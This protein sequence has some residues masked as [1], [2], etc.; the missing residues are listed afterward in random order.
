[1]DARAKALFSGLRSTCPTHS[2]QEL[3]NA[4]DIVNNGSSIEVSPPI[5]FR[6]EWA[7]SQEMFTA[8]WR[9]AHLSF[10]RREDR[11]ETFASYRLGTAVRNWL[12]RLG[13]TCHSRLNAE[14]DC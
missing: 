10:S 8:S 9:L 14:R 2:G 7:R 5:H 12:D 11:F 6:I 3:R 4:L 13:R 1:M